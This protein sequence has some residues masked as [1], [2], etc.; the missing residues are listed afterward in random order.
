MFSGLKI[1]TVFLSA[2]SKY[3]GIEEMNINLYTCLVTSVLAQGG[4][5]GS[6]YWGL[7]CYQFKR[8]SISTPWAL[9]GDWPCQNTY[10]SR[11][12]FW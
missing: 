3:M 7:M 11:G 1:R 2:T 10:S 6:C 9:D 12:Q 8:N 4:S 5:A